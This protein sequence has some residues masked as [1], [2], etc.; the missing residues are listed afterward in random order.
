MVKRIKS[1]QFQFLVVALSLAVITTILGLSAYL[2]DTES[3]NAVFKTVSGSELGFS[4][5]GE[6]FDNENLRIVTPGESIDIDAKAQVI[7]EVPLYLF[8][9]IDTPANCT[10]VD[11]NSAQW[12]P[13]P[14]KTNVYYFGRDSLLYTLGGGNGTSSDILSKLILNEGAEKDTTFTFSITG[15]AI[16]EKNLEDQAN[17]P[18]GVF[19]LVKSK[20]QDG[21]GGEP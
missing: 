13:V 15:Y 2:V 11:F 1:L 9:K 7:G 12:Q 5:V 8:V 17:D 18:E 21:G 19:S 4:I 16:Q 14:G 3:Y 20:T 6:T 10:T